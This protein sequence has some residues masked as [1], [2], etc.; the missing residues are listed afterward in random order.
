MNKNPVLTERTKKNIIEAYW[1]L[2]KEKGEAGAS[3]KEVAAKAGYHRSTVYSYFPSARAILDELEASLMPPYD[4]ILAAS[5]TEGGLP[6]MDGFTYSQFVE[7]ALKVYAAYGEYYSILLGD[8]GDHR[9]A[10]KLKGA[11]REIF[12][13]M[14]ARYKVAEDGRIDLLIEYEMG[15]MIG[16][17]NYWY[18]LPDKPPL[19]EL[20][21]FLY[22][23][24]ENGE[25]RY[26]Q[27]LLS[28][29]EKGK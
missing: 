15:A 25:K 21:G 9:F 27:S 8:H 4:K 5:L 2:Y 12:H 24:R 10:R 18:S 22:E 11:I 16:S 17:L 19:A 1:G 6:P 20:A 7:Q 23:I 28:P 26:L 14:A 13:A 3:M 29:S